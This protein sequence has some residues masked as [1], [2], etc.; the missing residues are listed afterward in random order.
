MVVT[1]GDIRL[2][3]QVSQCQG[4]RGEGHERVEWRDGGGKKR[5]ISLLDDDAAE[6]LRTLG[7]TW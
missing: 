4:G 7:S 2:L 1:D 5:D 6:H 3:G